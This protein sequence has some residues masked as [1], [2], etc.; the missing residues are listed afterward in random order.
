MSVI[1]AEKNGVSDGSACDFLQKINTEIPIV[2]I[3]WAENFV[4]N[5]ALLSVKDY[6]LVCFCEYGY[7]AV[8]DDTHIWG[9][10]SYKFPRYYSEGYRQFD[11][12]V[13]YNPPKIFFKRELLKKEARGNIH[14]IQYP[15][16]HEI[17]PVQSKEQF[18]NRVLQV[19]YSF[20]ISHEYR[21]ELHALIWAKS[22]AYGYAVA[23]NLYL[24]NQFI[25]AEKTPK[26]WLSVHIPYWARQPIETIIA[27]NGLAKVSISIAGAG[28]VCFRHMESPINSVMYM[29]EDE[30]KWS[31]D[32]IHNANCIKSKQGRE[33]E[34][35]IEALENPNLY[36]IYLAGVETVKKYQVT[37]YINNYLKPLIEKI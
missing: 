9:V 30:I 14:P 10:N 17:P 33:V 13:R 36:D 28:R 32:F 8:M 27:I 26:K 18:D 29:W 37:E 35:I 5:D 7:D 21:K 11:E 1:V 23:D 31:Y 22:G 20:G 4:F 25:E 12:W 19:F 34:T 3:S 2:L 16:L 6:V 24:L 15:C